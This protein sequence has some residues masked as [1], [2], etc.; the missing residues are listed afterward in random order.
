[1]VIPAN[2]AQ[3]MRI[4]R[5]L[6]SLSKLQDLLMNEKRFWSRTLKSSLSKSRKENSPVKITPEARRSPRLV[7]PVIVL[8]LATITVSAPVRSR[9]GRQ[10]ITAPISAQPLAQQQTSGTP[11]GVPSTTPTVVLD[12]TRKPA[13]TT[14][15]APA[16]QAPRPGARTAELTDFQQLVATSLGQTLPIY[17]ENLF[18]NV[19]TTF[20]PVDRVPVTA[21][22]VLGPGDELL[23]R[24]WGQIDLDVHARIDRNGA[25]Y[26]PKVGNLNVAGL[27]YTSSRIS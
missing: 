16:E 5:L 6:I 25:I 19:P 2:G 18:E 17:G 23:I 13:P 8:A 10:Q 12:D 4:V 14:A 1:M 9:P 3:T 15:P 20:A 26:I 27:R 24:A 7:L 11:E 22:Y 21:D